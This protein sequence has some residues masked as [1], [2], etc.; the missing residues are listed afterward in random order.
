MLASYNTYII[1]TL[2]GV[3]TITFPEK[4]DEEFNLNFKEKTK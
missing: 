2:I 1:N 3:R 4:R